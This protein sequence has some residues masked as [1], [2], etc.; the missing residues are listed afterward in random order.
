M[1]GGQNLIVNITVDHVYVIMG[2]QNRN[3][4]RYSI[5]CAALLFLFYTGPVST[6]LHFTMRYT[7]YNCVC[8]K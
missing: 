4:D 6:T 7:L 5:T 1:Q 2:T 8:D 3:R